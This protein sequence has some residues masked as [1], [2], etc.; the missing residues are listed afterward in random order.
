MRAFNIKDTLHKEMK[1]SCCCKNSIK[2]GWMYEGKPQGI[3]L[4]REFQ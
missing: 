2:C 4:V 1:V 3:Y